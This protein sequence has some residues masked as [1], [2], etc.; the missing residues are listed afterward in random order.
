LVEK[1]ELWVYKAVKQEDKKVD[2][3]EDTK[4]LPLVKDETRGGRRHPQKQGSAIDLDI[5]PP[6][7]LSQSRNYKTIQQI[8]YRMNRMCV[9]AGLGGTLKPRKHEQRLLR[10]MGV[11]KVV[12]DLLQIPFDQKE[13]VRMNELM[14]LAHQFLQNFCLSN[15]NNQVLLHKHLELFLNPDL[16]HAKTMCA[17]FQDNAVLCNE[18]NEKVVQHFVH[19]IESHGKHVQYLRFL[20]TIVHTESQFIRR[21][22]DLVM[23]ELV[24]A[25]EDVLIFYNDKASFNHFLEMMR[26]ERNRMDGSSPLCYHIELVSLVL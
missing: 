6:L 12:L 8:L 25:G 10:N 11:H 26:S 18:V 15:Q 1:S 13:D 17:I 16:L 5:G 2:D 24:N 14:R 23:Q 3:D 4:Q 9:Q 19:C 20:Q 7:E 22:Q 21:C